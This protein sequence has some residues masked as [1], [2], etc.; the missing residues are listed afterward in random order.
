MTNSSPNYTDTTAFPVFASKAA[1]LQALSDPQ[2]NQGRNWYEFLARV[3]NT[4][5]STF[6]DPTAGLSGNVVGGVDC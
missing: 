3:A 4:D 1:L 5:T 6:A 2:N